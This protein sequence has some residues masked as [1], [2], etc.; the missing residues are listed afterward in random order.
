MNSTFQNQTF[1]VVKFQPHDIVLMDKFTRKLYSYHDQSPLINS[2]ID[3]QMILKCQVLSLGLIHE[4]E[5][6]SLA[7][8]VQNRI[9]KSIK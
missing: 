5:Q 4:K 2:E 6:S 9:T 8:I 1:V 7:K 3:H